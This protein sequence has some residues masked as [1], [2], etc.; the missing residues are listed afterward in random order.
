MVFPPDI[1]RSVPN[2]LIVCSSV[3]APMNG[4]RS[5]SVAEA[6]FVTLS[7]FPTSSKSWIS[8]VMLPSTSVV[9]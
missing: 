4:A 9:K 6:L 3:L 5:I 8:F 7:V 2:K 1:D